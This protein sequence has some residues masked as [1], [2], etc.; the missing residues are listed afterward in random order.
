MPITFAPVEQDRAE[1]LLETGGARGL[2]LRLIRDFLAYLDSPEGDGQLSVEF[3][4]SALDERAD[5]KDENDNVTGQRELRPSEVA[6]RVKSAAESHNYGVVAVPDAGKIVLI[7]TAELPD[8][9]RAE[10]TTKER[11]SDNGQPVK[12]GR[13]SKADKEN[14]TA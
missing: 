9:E 3:A 6:Q 7:R 1:R 12:R 5:V 11:V 14:A 4:A 2:G 13:K 10:G 8:A